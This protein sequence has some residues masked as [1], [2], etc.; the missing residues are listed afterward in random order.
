MRE[1]SNWNEWC[2]FILIPL[3]QRDIA[4]AGDLVNVLLSC[5]DSIVLLRIY[6]AIIK[7][8]G[9][10]AATRAG[11]VRTSY[12]NWPLSVCSFNNGSFECR[13]SALTCTIVKWALPLL[14]DLREFLDDDASIYI[15]LI[16]VGLKMFTNLTIVWI[17]ASIEPAN[18][19]P[20]S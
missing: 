19:Y 17:L 4:V 20:L 2:V 10:R 18:E 16:R 11:Y 7:R 6:W 8:S 9:W 14:G 12:P 13:L 3:C 15:Y 1:N 5:E